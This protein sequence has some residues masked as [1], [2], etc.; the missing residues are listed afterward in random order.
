MLKGWKTI[1]FSTLMGAIMIVKGIATPED[2]ANAPTG[3][4]VTQALDMFELVYGLAVMAGGWFFRAVTN[5]PIFNKE[6]EQPPA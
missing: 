2:A 4:Q 6:P 3:E 5:S 1:I